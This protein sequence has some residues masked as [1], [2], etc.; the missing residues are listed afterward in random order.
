MRPKIRIALTTKKPI[1]LPNM[2]ND[3]CCTLFCFITW[4]QN[5]LWSWYNKAK[6][7]VPKSQKGTRIAIN[8]EKRFDYQNIHN[9]LCQTMFPSDVANQAWFESVAALEWDDRFLC[10][11]HKVSETTVKSVEMC[12]S[13]DWLTMAIN[14]WFSLCST[15]TQ[16]GFYLLQKCCNNSSNCLQLCCSLLPWHASLSKVSWDWHRARCHLLPV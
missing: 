16:N 1:F 3:A 10:N 9:Y 8:L 4:K 6:A 7:S 15:K 5:M 12:L 13:V 14:V 11:P 2:F